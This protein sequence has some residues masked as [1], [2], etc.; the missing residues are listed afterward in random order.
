MLPFFKKKVDSHVYVLEDDNFGV[1][2]GDRILMA[3]C[4]KIKNGTARV[5]LLTDSAEIRFDN[6][7]YCH[8]FRDPPPRPGYNWH[9]VMD[10]YKG[11]KLAYRIYT[12][13]F[14]KESMERSCPSPK[15]MDQ[16]WDLIFNS[17]PINWGELL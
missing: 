9:R 5:N 12:D 11:N 1:H 14:D 3:V 6:G 10:F 15:L 7:V 13:N 16:T 17:N 2:Y 4:D 8:C